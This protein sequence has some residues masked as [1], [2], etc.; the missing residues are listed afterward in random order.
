VIKIVTFPLRYKDVVNE[1]L[2]R[3]KNTSV[4]DP[5][6]VVPFD[7]ADYFILGKQEEMSEWGN[8]FSIMVW[9]SQSID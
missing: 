2:R 5:V 6:A 4:F 7:G 9:N 3:G 8:S 1:Q